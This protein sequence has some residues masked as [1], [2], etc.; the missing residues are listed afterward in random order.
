MPKT[1]NNVY[2]YMR[3]L[4]C[5][6]TGWTLRSLRVPALA[7]LLSPVWGVG[8][9]ATASAQETPVTLE[10]VRRMAAEGHPDVLAARARSD[11]AFREWDVARAYRLPSLAAEFDAV[12]STDPVAAFGSRLRQGRFTEADFAPHRL[13]EPDALGDWG[14]GLGLEWA[15]LDPAASSVARA[16]EALARAAGLGSDWAAR[17]AAF[18]AEL[19]YLESVGAEAHLHAAR[20]SAQAARENLRVTERRM[21]EGLAT[22][23]DVLQARAARENARAEVIR[24]ERQI[25]DSR[26]RLGLAL[27]WDGDRIPVPADRDFPSL[28]VS[29]RTLA[30]RDVEGRPDLQASRARLVASASRVEE[31]RRQRLPSMEGFARVGTHAHAP[32]SSPEA[33]WTLG[34]RVRL[35]LF[36]GGA[37]TNRVQALEAERLATRKEHDFLVREAEVEMGEAIRALESA[38]DALG[39]AVAAARASGEAARLMRRRYEQDLA[40][41]ADL[42][43]VESRA[44]RDAARE[45]SAATSRAM[46]AARVRFLT[47]THD[48]PET[49]NS[50]DSR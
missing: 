34:L 44:A 23:V 39:A 17:A 32:L 2:S 37:L 11:A 24:A 40:T 47:A 12:R 3:E 33:N 41:A 1:Y 4:L 30:A 8:G 19:H 13:N 46:A 38:E 18:R 9:A 15:P 6:N 49:P 10:E 27:G 45:V 16:S 14:A 43:T 5:R 50:G 36:T 31:A 26:E 21:E 48:R 20:T 25:R 35:P 22:E 28:P 29:T 42:V 7:L